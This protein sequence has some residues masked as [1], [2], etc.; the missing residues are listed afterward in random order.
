[1][2]IKTLAYIRD[3]ANNKSLSNPQKAQVNILQK[4]LTILKDCTIGKDLDLK[5][6]NN[7]V[8]FQ[9]KI[10]ITTYNYYENYIKEIL[11]GSI[12]VMFP[13]KPVCVAQ[14]GGTTSNPKQFPLGKHLIKSYRQFNLDMLFRYVRDSGNYDI[15]KG[16]I[17][18]VAASPSSSLTGQGVPIGR[19]TG[20]MAQIAP[21]TLQRRFVPNM[22][23]VR[24]PNTKQK[25][26][27]TNQ[28]VYLQR[29]D[30]T[31]AAGLTPYLMAAWNN[32]VK[33]VL[34]KEGHYLN[35]QEILPNL[36]VV[37][38]G[39]TTFTLYLEVMKDLTGD[40]VDHW[41]VYSAAEGP[42]AFQF[43]KDS[44]G[45]ALALNSVF[46][47]FLP[48]D[49]QD[50][51]KPQTFLV[52]DVE[53][54]VPYY[55]LLTTQGGLLRYKIGDLVEFTN[56]SPPLLK[57]IGRT[58]DQIDLSGEKL[59]VNQALVALQ[60]TSKKLGIKVQDFI[61]CPCNLRNETNKQIAHEWI[62]ESQ[63]QP[64]AVDKFRHELE[65]NIYSCNTRYKQLREHNFSLGLPE[66]T[67]VPIG[68]F[69]QYLEEEFIYG[70]Q[71]LLHMHNDRASV[72]RLLNYGK[73]VRAN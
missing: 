56:T 18:L 3:R 33:Y 6:I 46:F 49:Q 30:I 37:F 53:I 72:E 5:N 29:L 15:I 54:G 16:K 11:D 26:Q 63:N 62:I 41:N 59:D 13:G 7:I 22:N 68:T 34:Q 50:C 19:A 25:I 14:T 31:I 28:M 67:F 35:L 66:I 55:I 23:V 71:K 52:E 20:I 70:Q 21:S 24:N 48:Q 2:M 45:L 38:H 61:V 47:E 12:S 51:Q 39:G 1:M 44:Q 27:K 64:Q 57:V 8:E 10:P 73:K 43:S 17:F 40:K 65:D 4:I 9:N 32:L 42:I 69:Q 60:K 36:K 58:E